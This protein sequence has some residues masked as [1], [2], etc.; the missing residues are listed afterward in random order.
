MAAEAM[1][2]PPLELPRKPTR[3]ERLREELLNAP[4]M[5]TIARMALIPVFLAL[6]A[7]ESRR[8]SF[9]A[10]AIF[11]VAAITEDRKSTRL[12]SSHRH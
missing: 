7:Y 1:A 6:L 8:N 5:M 10:A 2:P 3:R 12:N 11:A 9:L 4:N